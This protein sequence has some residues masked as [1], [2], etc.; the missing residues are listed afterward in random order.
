MIPYDFIRIEDGVFVYRRADVDLFGMP[1]LWGVY[2]YI[3]VSTE[4]D[5]APQVMDWQMIQDR[6]GS[7]RPP[8][9]YNRVSRFRSLLNDFMGNRNVPKEVVDLVRFWGLD[10][11]QADVFEGV[12]KVLKAYGF[13]KYYNS[14]P[15]IIWMLR[16][17]RRRFESRIVEQVMDDFIRMSHRFDR[18][19][20]SGR[21]YFPNLRYVLL[22]LLELNGFEFGFDVVK[23]RTKR[24]RVVM[25]N[26]F[27]ELY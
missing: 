23:I 6:R 12:R 24:K 7:L 5:V 11:S 18:L 20:S 27:E 2:D 1:D 19:E 26:I 14:I 17:G 21:S 13:R 3:V 9:R 16:G 4:D 25:E 8:H 15:S 22:E 10:E